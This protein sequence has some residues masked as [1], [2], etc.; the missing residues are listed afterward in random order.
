M[1][2][3]DKLLPWKRKDDLALNDNIA[4][5]GFNSGYPSDPG[6]GGMQGMPGM[7]MDPNQGMSPYS[8]PYPSMGQPLGGFPQPQQPGVEAFQRERNYAAGKDI[9][10]V[11]AKLDAIKAALETLNQR[12]GTIERWIQ[13]DQDFRK[14][15]W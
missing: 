5:G 1:G 10:V 3:L 2:I 15:G 6:M 9:E 13:S 4:M 11:S 8:P 12:L 14:R 7:A